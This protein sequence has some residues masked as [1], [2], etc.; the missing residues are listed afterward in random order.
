MASHDRYCLLTEDGE[1]ST[2]K[3]AL[4]SPDASLWMTTMQEEM[5]ALHRN[6]TWELVPLPQGQKTI[7]NKWVYKIERDGNG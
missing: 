4:N 2:F 5:K 7:S 1:P 6:K 3:R